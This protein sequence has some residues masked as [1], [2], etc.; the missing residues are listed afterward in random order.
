MWLGWSE[1]GGD[2]VRELRGWGGETQIPWGCAV[3]VKA[4]AFLN[5]RR[6]HWKVLNEGVA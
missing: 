5:E 3:T 2:E 6:S 1:R 4:L